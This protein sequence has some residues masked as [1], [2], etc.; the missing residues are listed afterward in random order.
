[1]R[2][3]HW[4]QLF[5]QSC[6]VQYCIVQYIAQATAATRADQKQQQHANWLRIATCIATAHNQTHTQGTERITNN[7][8]THT[9]THLKIIKQTNRSS[10]ATMTHVGVVVAI[11][12]SKGFAVRCGNLSYCIYKVYIRYS[13]FP[14]HQCPD[15]LLAMLPNSNSLIV[16]ICLYA[17]YS[18]LYSTQ[19]AP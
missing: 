5:L 8:Q 6:T 2:D 19:V 4:R 14:H 16:L 17:Q 18:I 10:P 9:H 7:T 13:N 11:Y 12:H 3:I 15:G 1:L